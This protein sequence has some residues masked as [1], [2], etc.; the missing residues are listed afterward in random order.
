[1]NHLTATTHGSDSKSV[2]VQIEGEDQKQLRRLK[3]PDWQPRELAVEMEA[4]GRQR[5]ERLRIECLH[6][7]LSKN[8]ERALE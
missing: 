6:E 7:Q 5:G 8:V 3:L 4:T 2:K 1:L